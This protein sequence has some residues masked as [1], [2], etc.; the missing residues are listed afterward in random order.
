VPLTVAAIFRVLVTLGIATHVF[1]MYCLARTWDD[2]FGFRVGTALLAGAFALVLMAP[3]VWAVGLP[4]LPDV[5]VRHLRARRWWR[6]GRCPRC[7]YLVR[8]PGGEACPECG[9]P[10]G[11]VEPY[12]FHPALVR[13]FIVLCA[14]AWMLGCAT[15]EQWLLADERR[16]E[17]EA[18]AALVDPTLEVFT[19]R[20]TWP[21]GSRP[22]YWV[23]AEGA[24]AQRAYL[25]HLTAPDIRRLPFGHPAVGPPGP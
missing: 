9:R 8:D 3:F 10:A 17:A 15:G 4:E 16:F 25:E 1:G 22:L 23:R 11:P 14:V 12:R 7:G 18:R 5:Y 2:A 21:N 6:Q 13:R 20:R 24:M 19:R